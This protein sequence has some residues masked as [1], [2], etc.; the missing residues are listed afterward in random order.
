L[1]SICGIAFEYAVHDAVISAEPAVVERVADAFNKYRIVRGNP[2]AL[3]ARHCPAAQ[4]Q[5]AGPG[6]PGSRSLC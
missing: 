5:R 4:A 1:Q 3:S 6:S 2:A